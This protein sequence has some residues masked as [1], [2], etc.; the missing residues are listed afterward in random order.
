MKP[1]EKPPEEKTRISFGKKADKED[2]NKVKATP[3]LEK[4][5]VDLIKKAIAAIDDDDVKEAKKNLSELLKGEKSEIPP[6]KDVKKEDKKSDKKGKEDKADKEDDKY[7]KDDKKKSFRDKI[8]KVF[9]KKD[10]DNDD[11]E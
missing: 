7:E 6:K 3:K 9:D 11:E 4:H 8:H 10:N 5:H 2:D 1:E